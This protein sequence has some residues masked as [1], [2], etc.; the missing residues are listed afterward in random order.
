MTVTLGGVNSV[1]S[2]GSDAW[3]STDL[4]RL[5]HVNS[6]QFQSNSSQP[7][8]LQKFTI[9]YSFDGISYTTFKVMDVN[10]VSIASFDFEYWG[11]SIVI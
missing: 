5:Y 4:S 6:L 2:D 1:C 9:Q 11:L 3:P 8:E 10:V 7:G